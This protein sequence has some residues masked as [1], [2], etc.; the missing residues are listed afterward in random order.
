MDYAVGVWRT[1]PTPTPPRQVGTASCVA[2]NPSDVGLGD[3]HAVDVDI[4]GG[5]AAHAAFFGGQW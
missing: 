1:A 4:Y 3:E 5:V 2:T